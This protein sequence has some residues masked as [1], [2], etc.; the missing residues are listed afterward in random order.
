M[1]IRKPLPLA[2]GRRGR[3]QRGPGNPLGWWEMF[4]V[5]LVLD[6]GYMGEY[7]CQMH[8]VEH[9]KSVH[10]IFYI[11]F[12]IFH[13][14]I[15]KSMSRAS[16]YWT[17]I[18]QCCDR[19]PVNGLSN[20]HRH[21]VGRTHHDPLLIWGFAQPLFSLR[22][23]FVCHLWIPISIYHTA[24]QALRKRCWTEMWIPGIGQYWVNLC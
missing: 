9:L 11:K 2:G 21:L 7:S 12:Y 20:A 17:Y 18:L 3:L 16:V 4:T 23:L 8:Q 15:K 5:C 6:D 13:V 10:P 24:L 22:F 19:L 1:Q 14:S